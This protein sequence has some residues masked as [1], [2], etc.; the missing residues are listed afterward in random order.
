MSLDEKIRRARQRPDHPTQQEKIRIERSLA[1]IESELEHM[2]SLSKRIQRRSGGRDTPWHVSLW[3]TLTNFIFSSE[4]IQQLYRRQERGFDIVCTELRRIR[5][6]MES[7][8]ERLEALYQDVL[9]QRYGCEEKLAAIQDELGRE[10]EGYDKRTDDLQKDRDRSGRRIKH[11]EYQAENQQATLEGI[12]KRRKYL[13]DACVH[14][15]D[16]MQTYGRLYQQAT[17]FLQEA[18]VF[19][20]A[21]G[22]FSMDSEVTESLLGTL[23]MFTANIVQLRQG[24][25]DSRQKSTDYARELLQET[26]SAEQFQE[27]DEGEHQWRTT[28]A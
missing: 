11:L 21:S 23:D 10:R 4:D 17:G 8:R 7:G 25:Y 28:C 9:E 20:E 27:L 15:I 14:S 22:N 24:Y 16:I 2:I 3:T 5:E 6:G 12:E 19:R 18:R 13:H 26:E 1:T